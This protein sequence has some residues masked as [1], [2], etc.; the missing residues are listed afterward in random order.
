MMSNDIVHPPPPPFKAEL[1]SPR[2]GGDTV[3]HM[4]IVL[5]QVGSIMDMMQ[6]QA[7]EMKVSKL[8]LPDRYGNFGNSSS[9]N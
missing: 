6:A 4:P 3:P 7:Q 5:Q 1:F 2:I 8:I 9:K